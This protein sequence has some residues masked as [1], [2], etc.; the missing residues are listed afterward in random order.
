[1]E[2][3]CCYST[4]LGSEVPSP[5]ATGNTSLLCMS[6]ARGLLPAPCGDF[7]GALI[8]EKLLAESQTV[9]EL[10]NFGKGTILSHLK[11]TAGVPIPTC[12]ITGLPCHPDKFSC[13]G[14]SQCYTEL[15]CSENLS[16]R[17]LSGNQMGR[18]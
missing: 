3:S 12:L 2:H 13:A 14:G 1:M 11:F 5:L 8:L 15:G 10:C 4:N 6:P 16:G 18:C 9:I 7:W 17:L